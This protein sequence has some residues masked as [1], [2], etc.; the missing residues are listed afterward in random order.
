MKVQTIIFS[1]IVL[2]LSVIIS[3]SVV[4]GAAADK[5][6]ILPLPDLSGTMSL[7]QALMLRRTCREFADKPLSLKQIGQLCW[8]GQGITDQ[9]KGFRTAP[10]AGALFPMELFIVTAEGVDHYQPRGHRLERHLSGDHRYALQ[11]AGLNQEYISRA[12][13]CFV[14]TAVIERS[15]RKYKQRAEQYCVQESGHIAQN[16]LLQATAMNLA[17]VPIGGFDADKAA[18]VLKL[19]KNHKVLYLLPIGYRT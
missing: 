6:Q 9:V 3:T 10:S 8:A 19:P 15:A 13:A 18:A 14:I 2:A 1:S 5:N 12:P 16:I 4:T 11:V 7:E 17:G